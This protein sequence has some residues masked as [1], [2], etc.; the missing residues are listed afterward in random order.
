MTGNMAV[1]APLILGLRCRGFE[2]GQGSTKTMVREIH[3]NKLKKWI[4]SDGE[5]GYVGN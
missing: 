5:L 1:K 2:G 4:D 3:L